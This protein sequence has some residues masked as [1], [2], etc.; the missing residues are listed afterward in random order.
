MNAIHGFFKWLAII[1]MRCYDGFYFLGRVVHIIVIGWFKSALFSILTIGTS[2]YFILRLLYRT[3]MMFAYV[4]SHAVGVSAS[5]N[6]AASGA[7]GGSFIDL[8]EFINYGI[9]IDLIVSLIFVA[10][11]LWASIW[12]YRFTKSFLPAAS[13]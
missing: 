10:V 1:A 4:R 2:I 3:F 7:T 13:S 12:A 8:L 11:S 9:P 5:V 6:N